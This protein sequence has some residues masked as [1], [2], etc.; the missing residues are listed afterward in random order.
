MSYS[1]REFPKL[2]EQMA[3]NFVSDLKNT[4]VKQVIYLSGLCSEKNLSAHL[5]SRFKTE[6]IIKQSGLP[7]TV[8]RAGIV[9]GAGSAS[10]EIIRDLAEKLPLMVAPRW[11]NTLCQP[12]SILDVMRYLLQVLMHTCCFC[13]AF[14]IGGAY[15][16]SYREMLLI[17]S[18]IRRLR[19]YIFT[20]PA[21]TPRL[22]SYWL[23]LVTSVDFNLASSLVDS[24]KNRAVC[25][26]KSITEIFP[27]K[28]MGYEE[29]VMYA[30]ES[31]LY[32]PSWR[33]GPSL[34]K[35]NRG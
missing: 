4:L 30:L 23:Y 15:L 1:R 29:S 32:A 8:L 7:F 34:L 22:S 31:N 13:K 25:Q 2:E 26:E 33:D 18:H 9:T 3:K 27:E 35:W 17:Y 11:I 6:C 19:R 12:I 24:L 14:D 28:C 5:A 10:F 16:L 20:L 21:L